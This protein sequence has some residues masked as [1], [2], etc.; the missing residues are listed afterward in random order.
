MGNPIQGRLGNIQVPF[1]DQ[2]LHI[3]EEEGQQKGADMAA[4]HVGIGHDH[5]APIAQTGEVEIFTDADPQC[6]DKRFDLVV[7]QD[8]IQAGAFGVE[9]LTAQGQNSLKMTV[10]ALFG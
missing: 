6:G 3:A 2:R 10:T 4:V 8:L 5:D 9:D 1:F 7:A